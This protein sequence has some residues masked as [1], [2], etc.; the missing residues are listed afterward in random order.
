MALLSRRKTI[1][2][3]IEG[4]YGVDSIPTGSADAMLVKN[5]EVQPL[6]AELVQRDLVRDFLG[7]SDTLVASRFATAN[8]EV[9]LVGSGTL[10]RLPGWDVL[11]RACGYGAATTTTQAITSINRSG[12][13]ATVVTPAA[14]NLQ[15]GDRITISG[16]TQTEY[17]GEF[18]VTVTNATTFTYAVT[19]TPVSPATGTPVI[20]TSRVYNPVSI[21]FPS[22][23]LYYNVDGLLHR[24]T[25]CRGSFEINVETTQIPVLRFSFTG[26]YNAPSDTASPSTNFA[27]FQIPQVANTANTPSFSLFGFQGFMQSMTLNLTNEVNYRTLIGLEEVT[28]VDRRPAGT[29]VFEAPTVAQRDYWTSANTGTT[30]AMSLLHGSRN[31]FRV[32]LDAPRVSIGNPTYQSDNGVELL[33]IPFTAA[34][35]V[36]NDDLTIT[37]L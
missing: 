22:I 19:G 4:T 10:G 30:G 15:T 7:N 13:T 26:L 37:V 28:L 3:K 33:S 11:L 20:N 24:L 2:A 6:N 9:E 34:P 32:R 1:L 23:T 18:Q 36:G 27:N 14:H 8:F 25:G 17:N 5:L 31:G 29:F 16:A 21:N 35:S 12:A